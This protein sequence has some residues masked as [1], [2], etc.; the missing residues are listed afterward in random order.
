[1]NRLKVCSLLC[2]N[3]F[4][5]DGLR[6]ESFSSRCDVFEVKQVEYYRSLPLNIFIGMEYF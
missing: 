1:M 5:D 4:K 2:I 3:F 6:L